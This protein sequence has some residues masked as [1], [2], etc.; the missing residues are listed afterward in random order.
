MSAPINSTQIL[1]EWAD[2]SHHHK[3]NTHN[4]RPLKD[5]VFHRSPCSHKGTDKHLSA[6]VLFHDGHNQDT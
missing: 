2:T 4:N 6:F 3:S 1:A 5:A